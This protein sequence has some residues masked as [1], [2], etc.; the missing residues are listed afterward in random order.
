M[1]RRYMG[2]NCSSNSAVKQYDPCKIN[3]IAS[4]NQIY[5][6]FNSVPLEYDLRE[7]FNICEEQRL[8]QPKLNIGADCKRGAVHRVSWR[9]WGNLSQTEGGYV[10]VVRETT[11]DKGTTYDDKTFSVMGKIDIPNYFMPSHNSKNK[12]Q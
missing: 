8:I 2:G 1:N 9:E 11:T 3:Q 5:N 12:R 6:K 7:D 4:N 10:S